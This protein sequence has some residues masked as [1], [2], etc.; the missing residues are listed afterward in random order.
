MDPLTSDRADHCV[1][2]FDQVLQELAGS[3]QL[4]LVTLE[5]LSEVRTVQVAVAELQSRMPHLL[6][7]W[8]KET[9]ESGPCEAASISSEE[10]CCPLEPAPAAGSSE[11]APCPS[12]PTSC[13]RTRCFSCYLLAASSTLTLFFVQLSRLV[14]HLESLRI[15]PIPI[16]IEL[17]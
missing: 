3:L 11:E 16:R 13:G 15:R 10:P 12:L 5:S 2:I 8:T 7:E 1:S 17:D 6:D 14:A 9:A 4:Q